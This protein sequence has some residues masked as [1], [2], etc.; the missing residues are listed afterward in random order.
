[1]EYL[2]P[3]I[4]TIVGVVLA[5]FCIWLV[6]SNRLPVGPKNFGLQLLGLGGIL[7]LLYAYNRPFK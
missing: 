5:V 3:V 6:V 2:K 1:M 7:A 4:K